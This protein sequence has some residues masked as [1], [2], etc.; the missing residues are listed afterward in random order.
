MIENSPSILKR[1]MATLIDGVFVITTFIIVSY[2]LSGDN[3]I[4]I[5]V[6]I[7]LLLC[8]FFAYEPVCTSKVCTL[9]QKIMGIRVRSKQTLGKISL[10]SAYIR[11]VV[12]ILLGFISFLTIPLS[13]ER[14]A[15]HDFAAGSVVVDSKFV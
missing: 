10:S 7:G 15:I 8:L 13:K 12:K 1:Y 6:R 11:I 4:S 3:A 9:G 14:R 5:P 2:I